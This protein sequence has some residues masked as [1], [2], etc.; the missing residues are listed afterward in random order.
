MTVLIEGGMHEE[1]ADH[2]G[3]PHNGGGA[4]GGAHT[5]AGGG[6][7]AVSNDRVHVGAVAPIGVQT[8]R[9][10]EE[11]SDG[12]AGVQRAREGVHDIRPD[13]RIVHRDV[14]QDVAAGVRNRDAVAEG[15]H[16]RATNALDTSGSLAVFARVERG[17]TSAA[18]VGRASHVFKYLNFRA[19]D[20]AMGR[21]RD[22]IQG[23][24]RL[25]GCRYCDGV[26]LYAATVT[27]ERITAVIDLAPVSIVERS[28]S[29]AGARSITAVIRSLVPVANN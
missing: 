15:R 19:A 14:I 9:L 17:A 26:I 24:S 20:R 22:G 8:P 12:V 23:F 27:S 7:L 18:G 4:V 16:L 13:G 3:R 2:V 29:S 21:G 1:R 25:V 11:V 28:R 6:A 10:A 5:G